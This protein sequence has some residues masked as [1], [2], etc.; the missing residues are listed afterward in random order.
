M[1]IPRKQKKK[2]NP[3]VKIADSV[4][5][6][7]YMNSNE[8]ATLLAPPSTGLSVIQYFTSCVDIHDLEGP[9]RSTFIDLRTLIMMYGVTIY[10]LHTSL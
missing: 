3:K 8:S 1:E 9:C 10:G 5:L 6:S 2:S 7:L 4:L